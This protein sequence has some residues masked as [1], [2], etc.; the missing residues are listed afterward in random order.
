MPL[1][2]FFSGGGG[3]GGGGSSGDSDGSLESEFLSEDETSIHWVKLGT[4]IVS[5]LILTMLSGVTATILAIRD[6][7]TGVI[8]GLTNWLADEI[9]PLLGDFPRQMMREAVSLEAVEGL[10]I[11]GLA[12]GMAAVLASYYVVAWGVSKIAWQ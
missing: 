10:S 12:A 3:G 5:G 6:A 9:I 8:D 11:F 4:T 7:V 2:E 1:G